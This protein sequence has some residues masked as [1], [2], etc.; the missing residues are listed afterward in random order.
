MVYGIWFPSTRITSY[1][2]RAAY[3]GKGLDVI[4]S[5]DSMVENSVP[6]TLIGVL[7]TTGTLGAPRFSLI[8]NAGGR[9][10]L[11]G[12]NN[13]SVVAGLVPSDYET[14]PF[15][16][17]VVSVTGVSP[18][19]PNITFTVHVGN[20]DE[21]PPVIIS[22][23]GADTAVITIPEN[24]TAVTTVV[25]TDED[26]GSVVTYSILGGSDSSRFRIDPTTGVLAFVSSPDF[27]NPQTPTT[28]TSTSLSC[29][30]VTELSR[31]R[32]RSPLRGGCIRP[33]RY[34]PACHHFSVEP[35]YL[36]ECGACIRF[37]VEN[38][39]LVTWTISAV[40]MP[41][42]LQSLDQCCS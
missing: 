1:A 37:L 12:T 25:A 40:R 15:F 30:P 10:A 2:L 41:P 35:Q 20:A 5:A 21:F 38:D 16:N 17:F 23:G 11:G 7:S 14:T 22:N 36:R 24:T 13:T 19:L 33:H 18:Q 31:T 9:V 4:L 27:E 6:G 34:D 39:E 32:S 28:T 42:C 26:I 8:D 3:G 29:R